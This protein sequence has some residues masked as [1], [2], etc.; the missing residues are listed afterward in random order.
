[1][2]AR[3]CVSYELFIYG[4]KVVASGKERSK[5]PSSGEV[6]ASYACATRGDVDK[7]VASAKHAFETPGW[8]D[9]SVEERARLIERAEESLEKHAENLAHIIM[10]EVGKTREGAMAEVKKSAGLV[11]LRTSFA[12][13][14]AR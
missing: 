8:R 12:A 9:L 11:A 6:V 5:H 7:A 13:R 10:A 1:V 2:S 4:K 3:E 14:A